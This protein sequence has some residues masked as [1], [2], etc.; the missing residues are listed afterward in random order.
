MT[1]KDRDVRQFRLLYSTAIIAGFLATLQISD[2]LQHKLGGEIYA[3]GMVIFGISALLSFIHLLYV[4]V[5]SKYDKNYTPFI[6]IFQMNGGRDSVSS[7]RKQGIAIKEFC[8]DWSINIFFLL[9]IILLV[10]WL[11]DVIFNE[12]ILS[13]GAEY[14]STS[15][16]RLDPIKDGNWFLMAGFFSFVIAGIITQ[17]VYG[18]VSLVKN[19]GSI[20]K[21]SVKLF[22]YV[23]LFFAA[24]YGLLF[25][26]GGTMDDVTFSLPI[27]F[28]IS[29]L[30]VVIAEL[31]GIIDLSDND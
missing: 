4:A 25:I 10:F 17:L 12:K 24:I 22:F 18:P 13:D 14:G 7:I 26:Q 9:P 29:S 5:E 19:F 27:I 31:L 8:F 15:G 30:L 6:S 16:I 28:L 20:K 1:Q 21:G 3:V 11:T 2:R 23:L